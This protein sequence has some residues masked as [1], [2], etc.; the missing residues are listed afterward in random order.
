MNININ[1]V[2]RSQFLLL[3]RTPSNKEVQ[4]C[5]LVKSTSKTEKRLNRRKNVDTAF[6]SRYA[7][8][9]CYTFL[10]F[11]R[12]LEVTSNN[13]SKARVCVYRM[14]NASSENFSCLIQKLTVYLLHRV[15]TKPRCPTEC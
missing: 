12:I 7:R 8:Y 1:H 6:S 9:N 15:S 2:T 5:Q 10:F 4:S 14:E 11:S 13:T 3:T